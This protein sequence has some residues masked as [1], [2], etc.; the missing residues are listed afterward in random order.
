M[1]WRRHVY[2][3][4]GEITMMV[5]VIINGHTN[6]LVL[7]HTSQALLKA[8]VGYY[9]YVVHIWKNSKLLLTTLT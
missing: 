6:H 4:N 5:Y 9:N 7:L 8:A 3:M 1:V 2:D